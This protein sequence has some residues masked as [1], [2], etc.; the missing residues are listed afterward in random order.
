M[1]I[2]VYMYIERDWNEPTFDWKTLKFYTLK[3]G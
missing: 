3:V 1:Y 2:C